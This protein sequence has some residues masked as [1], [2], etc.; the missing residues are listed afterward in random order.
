MPD[1][2]QIRTVHN[3]FTGA[4]GYTQMYFDASGSTLGAQAASDAVHAF[5]EALA[6]DFPTSWTYSIEADVETITDST[7]HLTGVTATT[8]LAQATFGGLATYA[9]GVGAV[10][11]W[12]TN[13]VHGSRRL[14]GRTF[15]V[16][17]QTGS[18]E[19][20]GTLA[21][22]TLS[23]LRAAATTLVA[24]QDFGVWGRPVAGA[25][26]LF[27]NAAASNVRDHVAWLSSRRD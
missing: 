17:L 23:R 22:G 2:F 7:G 13:S 26:G 21:A 10:C 14:T 20:N 25:N 6:A 18:Y 19:S 4:P 27:A 16:P 5:W 3:G 1:M 11:K 9:G 15:V 24:Q 8:P 12:V